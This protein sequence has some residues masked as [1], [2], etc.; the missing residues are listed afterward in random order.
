[1]DPAPGDTLP[2][3]NDLQALARYSETYTY[4]E[5]GNLERIQ[6]DGKTAWTRNYE[7]FAENNRLHFTSVPGSPL[8]LTAAYTYDAHG[9]MTS[10]PEL[11]VMEWDYA[12]RL[13]HTRKVDGVD[14]QDTYFTYDAAGQRV[15]KVATHL[16]VVKER[17]YLGGYEVYRERMNGT[18]TGLADLERQTLHVSDD[19]RRVAMV[20]TKTVDTA[21]GA[22]GTGVSRWRFQLDNHLGSA[23]LEL[24]SNGAAI[25]YEEYHPYGSTAFHVADGN[26]EVSAKRYR[27]T[28]KERDEETGLYYHG[29]R[30]YAPWLGRWTSADPAGIGQPGQVDLNLYA[31]VRGDPIGKFDPVGLQEAVA[32]GVDDKGNPVLFDARGNAIEA[33]PN[34]AA[35]A[36]Q[37]PPPVP[38]AAA[39]P[40]TNPFIPLESQVVPQEP[41]VSKEVLTKV[42]AGIQIV[43]GTVELVGAGALALA[44]E[45]TGITKAGAVVLGAH[46]LDTIGAGIRTGA[47]GEIQETFTQQAAEA[48][49]ESLG[50]S[51]GVA[52][53]VGIIVDIGAGAGPSLT[54]AF[55]RR[56]AAEGV[57]EGVER[58]VVQASSEESFLFRGTTVGFEGSP[59]L[60]RIGVTPT[61]TDPAVAT[62]FATEASRFGEGVV[63]LAPRSAVPT[64]PGN[65]LAALE[66]EVG[67]AL[68]PV[69]FAARAQSVNLAEARAVLQQLGVELPAQ[70][71]GKAV[72]DATLRSSGRLTPEQIAEFVRAVNAR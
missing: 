69:E 34:E 28:S 18:A 38:G 2:H 13:R 11:D 42:V 15:R 63:L 64:I 12:D 55:T 4:D 49:A 65:V 44:P 70:V 20:E 23:V 7:Y 54:V 41:R 46:G 58:L 51:P 24:D 48:G 5:V 16:N 8:N 32:Q 22:T 35:I 30:Y 21:S 71:G 52:K 29:A 10:M 56:A 60:Q 26:A 62:L 45:P 61:S 9:S 68:K 36:P 57:E 43:G 66:A 59:A 6:H 53:G 17:I 14:P 47:S 67:V 27:Y 19:Q 50:A 25:S 40:G 39:P 31:Y 1:M 3:P 37:P 72:L 33:S